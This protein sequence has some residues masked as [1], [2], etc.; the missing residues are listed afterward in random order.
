MTI[1]AKEITNR[2]ATIIQDETGTRWPV[3]ELLDWLNDGQREIVL[4]K[5]DASIKNE[6]MALTSGTK[7]NLPTDGIALIDV[8]RNMGSGES[9][10]K[11]IRHIQRRILDDQ[12]PNWHTASAQSAVDHFAFDAR[13]P[14]HFYVYPPSDGT[15]QVEVIY[16]AAPDVIAS[17][18]DEISLDDIYSNALLDYILYRA[19]SKDSDYTG[20]DNRAMAARSSFL[21]SLGRQDMAEMIYSPANNNQHPVPEEGHQ[22]RRRLSDTM[23]TPSGA[24]TSGQ[25]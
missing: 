9:A 13:D 3:E 19:Y 4:L 7:Q 15:S 6:S 5:P 22:W 10:G 20:N 16:S 21:Q 2:A 24:S 17:K 23:A 12:L 25:G 14:K 1:F 8:P 18:E 11:V